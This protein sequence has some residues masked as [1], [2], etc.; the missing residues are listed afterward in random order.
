[1]ADILEL[2]KLLLAEAQWHREYLTSG[3]IPPVPDAY[4]E[5]A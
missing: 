3:L 5:Q 1:M 4:A 2:L